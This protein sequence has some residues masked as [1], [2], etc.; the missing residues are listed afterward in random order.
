MVSVIRRDIH[1]RHF[2]VSLGPQGTIFF[3]EDGQVQKTPVF[4][5]R[6]I[7]RTGA[8]DALFAVTAPCLY[9]Q[10]PPDV[11]G[12]IAN[13]VGAIAVEIVCNREPVDP[14]VLKKFVTYLLK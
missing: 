1:A 11:L 4:S 8:G 2:M 14:M 10:C 5:S 9:T 13:C 3:A 6:I 7:D 12:F